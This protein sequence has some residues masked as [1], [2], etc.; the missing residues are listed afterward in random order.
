MKTKLNKT[1]RQKK[2]F[3]GKTNDKTCAVFTLIE[4]LVVIAIIAIL[5]SMLLPVLSSARLKAKSIACTSH[6]K[7]LSAGFISYSDHHDEWLL[8]G[9]TSSGATESS[10][11][12]WVYAL[13]ELM[14]DKAISSPIATGISDF[15]ILFCPVESIGLGP[16]PDGLFQYGHFT[17]N[18]VILG[19]SFTSIANVP[20]RKMTGVYSSSKALILLD[21]ARI[22]GYRL[23]SYSAFTGTSVAYRHDRP[24]GALSG[25]TVLYGG[26]RTNGAYLDGHVET[27][28]RSTMT[29]EK[30]YEGLKNK[31][32]D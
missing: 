17:A 14:F 12:A 9:N 1:L 4:L 19:S 6:L 5:A 2:F 29:T 26:N 16:H 20:T 27:I 23:N 18:S 21:N 11:R 8:P 3:A 25:T 13:H 28:Q 10:S 24:G 7:Q 31:P 15:K 32:I 30:S 22:S